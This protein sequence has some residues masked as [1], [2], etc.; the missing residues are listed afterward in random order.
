[1]SRILKFRAWDK[2]RKEMFY[3][4]QLTTIV[5][6]RNEAVDMSCQRYTGEDWCEVMQYIPM[7]NCFEGDIVDVIDGADGLIEEMKAGR[8][9]V[10]WSD[11][12]ASFFLE[13][14]DKQSGISFDECMSVIVVGNIYENPE[15]ISERS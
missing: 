15:L 6:R 7:H 8:Y 10:T 13:Q 3:P 2:Q 5:Y 1:M 11:V 12:D 14:V 9:V 4:S